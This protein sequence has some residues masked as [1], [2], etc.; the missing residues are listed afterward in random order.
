MRYLLVVSVALTGGC[1]DH[2]SAPVADPMV[3]PE[4]APN[5]ATAGQTVPA[6]PGPSP[7]P[8]SQEVQALLYQA[9]ELRDTGRFREALAVADQALARDPNSPAAAALRDELWSIV[10]KI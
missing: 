2:E 6:P 7:Y 5:P 3:T 10:T 8:E 4:A 1:A 9:R